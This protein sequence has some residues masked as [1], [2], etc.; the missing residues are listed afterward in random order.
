VYSRI[1]SLNNEIDAYEKSYQSV[2]ETYQWICK[3]VIEHKKSQN[4]QLIERIIHLLKNTYMDSELCLEAIADQFHISK[5]YASQFFKDQTGINFSDYLEN[6]RMKQAKSLLQSSELSINE[7]SQKVGYSSSNSFCRA[8]KRMHGVSATSY[9]K[10]H[11]QDN[12]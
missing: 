2:R 3:G 5:V 8:F 7:I 9:K 1:H 11:E 6:L 10:L 4:I 12:S